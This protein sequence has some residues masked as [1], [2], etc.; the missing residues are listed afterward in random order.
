MKRGLGFLLA[1]ALVFGMAALPSSVAHATEA[2]PALPEIPAPIDLPTP[3]DEPAGDTPTAPSEVPDRSFYFNESLRGKAVLFYG[4]SITARHGLKAT[5]KDYVDLI[6]EQLGFYVKNVASSGASWTRAIDVD[7]NDVFRQYEQI[8][9]L[10]READCV[11]VFLGT[12]DFGR[13]DAASRSIGTIDDMPATPEEAI[14]VYGAMNLFFTNLLSVNPD[15]KINLFTP[16][17]YP[18]GFEQ[19]NRY[20]FNLGE[21]KDA[22][23]NIAEKYGCRVIDW[24]SGVI[25]EENKEGLLQ[26]DNTHVTPE[27]Y[28]VMADWLLAL[29]RDAGQE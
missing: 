13:G 15:V 9:I 26:S 5:D 21:V 10:N 8:P 4:D 6:Q 29:D 14:T 16:V 24:S 3:I 11:C 1:G 28:R 23:F 27:G 25:T 17:W 22:I 7:T 2:E 12:N 18:T 20:G 19:V